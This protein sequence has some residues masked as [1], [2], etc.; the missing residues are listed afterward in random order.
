MSLSRHWGLIRHNAHRMLWAGLAWSVSL[1]ATAQ[2]PA[3]MPVAPQGHDPR[4]WLMRIHDAASTR[5]YQGT[6]VVTTGGASSSSRVAHFADGMEQFERV[7]WLDGEA[8]SLL[9]HN[10][11][12]HTLWPKARVAVVEQRD[13]R[14]IFPALLSGGDR[15]VL[16]WYELRPL[17]VDR[18]A[19]LDADVMLLRA[20]DGLR[21]SQR[22]WAERRS[23]L[24]LR[25][26]VLSASGQLLESVAFSELAIGVKAQPELVMATLKHLQGY[27]VIRAQ[28]LP[29]QLG[30][31]GWSLGSTPA[32]FREVH[33]ARR[34]LDPTS[35]DASPLVLQSIY[36]DG[37]THV[38]LFIEPFEPRRHQAEVNLSL[39][40]TNTV[41][42]RRA[43][44]WVTAM[45]DVPVDTLR[46][47][48]DKLNRRR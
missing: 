23:G 22:L 4:A 28:A 9:R 26:D 17:G 15:R 24:L 45:G 30:N 12:V 38:S 14:A 25:A 37:L 34:S 48:I 42:A 7:D 1:G 6:L 3:P 47:F 32:G 20:R 27:R 46:Q 35:P 19:G 41:T 10:D 11:V 29:A 8:R 16:E 43:E 31:E 21:F 13:P 33:C 18:V 36:S 2:T 40:A 39:G 44:Y 5:N